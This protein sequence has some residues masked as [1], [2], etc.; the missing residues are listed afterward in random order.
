[1]KKYLVI[2]YSTKKIECIIILWWV[3]VL[4]FV[5]LTSRPTNIF[6]CT[7]YHAFTLNAYPNV[8]RECLDHHPNWNLSNHERVEDGAKNF[9]P[10][11]WYIW[12]KQLKGNW[13]TILKPNQC[14][15]LIFDMNY[16]KWWIGN[17]KSSVVLVPKT[18]N[19]Q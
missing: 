2:Y 6:N 7:L 16:A 1:M 8:E 3:L 5:H 18:I 12:Y 11:T 9:D 10:H 13:N 19:Y 4:L 17:A 15:S 14:T